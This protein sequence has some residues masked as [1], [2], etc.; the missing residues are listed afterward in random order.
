M[1]RDP[2]VV[3]FYSSGAWKKCRASYRKSVGG[4][5]ERC[6]RRGI[7]TPGE[8]VH[9]KCYLTPENIDDPSITLDW[10]NLE[11]LCQAHHNEEHFKEQKQKRY[12]IDKEGNV[13][14]NEYM[15][16]IQTY[17]TKQ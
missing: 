14:A 7:Y 13:I 11:C 2:K 5:C 1:Q 9:H 17:D 6:L 10:N 4:L 16:S 8:I 15:D 3:Q 12:I